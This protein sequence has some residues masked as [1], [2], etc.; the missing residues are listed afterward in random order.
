M[1]KKIIFFGPFVGTILGLIISV[2]GAP[3]KTAIIV[4]MIIM[5]IFGWICMIDFIKTSVGFF[6]TILK[7]E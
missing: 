5:H 6:S 4:G 1:R 3:S 2:L 7:S